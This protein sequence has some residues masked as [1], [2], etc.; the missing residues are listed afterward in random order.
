MKRL[1]S[2]ILTFLLAFSIMPASWNNGTIE[3]KGTVIDS[4]ECGPSLTWE[5]TSDNVLTISGTGA[6]YNYNYNNEAPWYY[7]RTGTHYIESESGYSI[8]VSSNYITTI[9]VNNGV[10]S[11]GDYAFYHLDYVTNISLPSSV[12]TIG[13]WSF[14]GTAITSLTLPASLVSIGSDAFYSCSQLKSIVFPA[15]L[16]GIGMWA[17]E[18]CTS[19][20]SIVIPS[21]V[22]LNSYVFSNCIN[23]KNVVIEKGR[24]ELPQGLFYG[25]SA[26]TNIVIPEGITDINCNVFEDC[27]QLKQISIPKSVTRIGYSIG[28]T[29]DGCY[30]LKEVDYGGSENDWNNIDIYENND[31]L[32]SANIYYNSYNPF[33]DIS[34]ASWCFSPVLWAY[35]TGVTTGTT[36]TTFEPNKTC[37]RAE[38]V[39]FLYKYMGMP[40]NEAWASECN[41]S[42][43]KSSNWF[44]RAVIWAN[45]VGVTHGTTSTTFSPNVTLDRAMVISFLY[46]M[47][48]Y[49]NR[50]PKVTL[51]STKFTDVPKS[52]YYYDPVLWAEQYQITNGSTPTTFAPADNCTRA[53]A[54]AFLYNIDKYWKR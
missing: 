51:T 12:T 5:F 45:H 7:Y 13:N 21:K 50:K 34:A 18:S 11:I 4:G 16:K 29:F 38:F 41:F 44:Y 31:P 23:L 24:T 25:C 47:E 14:T 49:Q 32:L 43:V 53:E 19:L 6:M 35:N 36:V 39:A 40:W 37:T 2:L 46:N 17:F 10:S 15:S 9:I 8:N 54:V 1:V 3:A 22:S 27:I 20:S 26:L 42:D 30:S 28:S 33:V 48:K 52:S